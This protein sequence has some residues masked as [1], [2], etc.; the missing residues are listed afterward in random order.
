[1]FDGMPGEEVIGKTIDWTMNN[2]RDAFLNGLELE[3]QSNFWYLPGLFKGLVLNVNFTKQSSEAKYP[4][5]DKSQ[6]ITGYDTTE[7]FGEIRITPIRETV[8]TDTFYTA[9]MI[10]QADEIFN[11]TI[12]Y[13]YKGFSIRASMKYTDDLF[14]RAEYNENYNEFTKERFDYDIAIRQKLPVDGL[15]AYCNITNIGRSKYVAI[16]KGSGRPTV[17]RYGGIGFAFGLRYKF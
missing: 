16:N 13:G 5:V 1:M 10:D 14:R 8:Y 11:L 17:E 7:V 4:I 6:I 9:R 2:S 12:G 3:W 15:N